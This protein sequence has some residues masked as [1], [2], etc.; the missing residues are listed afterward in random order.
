VLPAGV[1]DEQLPPVGEWNVPTVVPTQTQPAVARSGNGNGN[2]TTARR[3]SDPVPGVSA[4]PPAAPSRIVEAASGKEIEITD[5]KFTDRY[6]IV[7]FS[8]LRW[9]FV[10]Q[11]PQQFLSRFAKKHQVLFVEEPFFDRTE[12]FEPELSLHQ[13]MPNVTVACPH[14]AP[15]WATNPKLP[16]LLREQT[17]KAIDQMNESGTFDRPLLWYY[18]PMDA[19]WSLGHFAN[20]GIVYDSMDELSQFTGAPPSLVANEQRLMKYADVVFTGGYELYLKKKQYHDNVHFFGCGVEYD[21]FARAQ[22]PTISIPP[23]IDFLGRPILGWFGVVD[24]RVDYAMLGDIAR[25]KPDWS[26]AIIGPVVKVDPNT[27]PHFPNLFWMGG[28]DYSVLPNYCKAFDVCLMPF[29]NNAST[30]YINPTK[31]LEYFATGRPVVSTPVRDVVRQYS[32]L[33]DIAANTDEFIKAVDRAL[34]EPNA[35]RIARGIEKARRCSWEST[36]RDMQKLIRDAIKPN[37][38]R[39]ASKIAP[40]ADEAAGL[41][42]LY[43]PTQGS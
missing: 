30:Q 19:S 8:H 36:V 2:K 23:D 42:Y 27:L 21:H 37:D 9:G 10:W 18:S 28:R 35:E 40:V 17:Q 7:V 38:R 31:A 34:R 26:L 24:E 13:V 20:R 15:S 41:A 5:D 39:S 22:D 14:L 12:G 16:G 3:L 32:D 29:A 33:I 11:R 43:Q 4:E 25:A 1:D 6:G